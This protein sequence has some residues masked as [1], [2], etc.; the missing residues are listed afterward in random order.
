MTEHTAA[1][2]PQRKEPRLKLQFLSHGTLESRDLDKTRKF[3][4]EFLGLEV[5]QTSKISLMIRLG[6]EHSYAVVHNPRKEP[7]PRRAHN[8]LDVAKREDVD[9]AYEIVKAEQ[10][11]WGIGKCTRPAD[12]HGTYSFYFSDLDDNWWEILANPEGGYGWMF[13]QGGEIEQW[14]AGA[15]NPNQFTRLHKSLATTGDED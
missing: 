9:R 3:Y 7:M 8:G 4:E 13:G 2:A 14:G 12:H 1:A 15:D 5:V 10:A 6:G 11:Q